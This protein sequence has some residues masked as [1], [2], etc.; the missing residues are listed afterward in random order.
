ME[1]ADMFRTF[2]CTIAAGILAI[3]LTGFGLATARADPPPYGWFGSLSGSYIV[4]D[5]ED[6][7]RAISEAG[8]RSSTEMMAAFDKF[9]AVTNTRGEPTCVNMIVLH[10]RVEQSTKLGFS[11]IF[12]D[13]PVNVWSVHIT[14]PYGEAWMLY[15]EELPRV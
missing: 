5:T 15:C 13:V 9:A 12:K 2:I 10:M 6:Q 14:N 1:K 4:C 11:H 3:I 8:A 7:V